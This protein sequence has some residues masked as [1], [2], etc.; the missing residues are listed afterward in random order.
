[1]INSGRKTEN[2]LN[3]IKEDDIMD[4]PIDISE[5]TENHLDPDVLSHMILKPKDLNKK[6]PK[7]AKMMKGLVKKGG[8]SDIGLYIPKGL[9][10]KEFQ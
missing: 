10:T 2:Q 7:I 8:I 4:H 6:F 9:A 1:M 3:T 5:K